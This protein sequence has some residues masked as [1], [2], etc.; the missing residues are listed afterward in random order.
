MTINMWTLDTEPVATAALRGGSGISG[1]LKLIDEDF[2]A[3]IRDYFYYS[4]IRSH[5]E[6]TTQK[7]CF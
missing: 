4:Q 7:Y 5:G 1:Y 3:E 6:R 2:L